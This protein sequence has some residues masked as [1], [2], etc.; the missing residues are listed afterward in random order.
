MKGNIKD[1]K[2]VMVFRV[3]V[4]LVKTGLKMVPIEWKRSSSARQPEN[5]IDIF[6]QLKTM[7]PRAMP[8]DF[9]A[10][11]SVKTKTAPV[12]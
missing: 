5:Y 4:Y 7:L 11:I 3:G 2:R 9:V 1:L 10:V 12:R 8:S 6:Q